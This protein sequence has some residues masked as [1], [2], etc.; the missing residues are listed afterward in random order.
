LRG[1]L[2]Q[3]KEAVFSIF[4]DSLFFASDGEEMSDDFKQRGLL[5]NLLKEEAL[6][7]R[8]LLGILICLSL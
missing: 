6:A 1:A 2:L 8:Q 7:V 5:L 3:G 4:T